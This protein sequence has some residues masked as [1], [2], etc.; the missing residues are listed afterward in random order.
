MFLAGQPAHYTSPSP[1]Y[2]LL[3]TLPR[4]LKH[5]SALLQRILARSKKT[6]QIHTYGQI[7]FFPPRLY[8]HFRSKSKE[9]VLYFCFIFQPKITCLSKHTGGVWFQK[10]LKLMDQYECLAIQ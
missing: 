8:A 3:H 9:T 5:L 2:T 7:F 4:V 1:L 10:P 6:E